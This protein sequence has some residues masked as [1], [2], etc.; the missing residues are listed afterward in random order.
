MLKKRKWVQGTETYSLSSGWTLSPLGHLQRNTLPCPYFH[1]SLLL[2]FYS[3]AQLSLPPGSLPWPASLGLAHFLGSHSLLCLYY[4]SLAHSD[5]SLS[6]DRSVSIIGQETRESRVRVVL[7]IP[8]SPWSPRPGQEGECPVSV[9][10][11]QQCLHSLT[12]HLLLHKALFKA[13]GVKQGSEQAKIP[14]FMELTVYGAR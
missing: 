12:E 10:L 14:V 9:Y 5:V 1:D 4:S 3:S 7:I 13:L 11:T 6:S 8:R 2:I